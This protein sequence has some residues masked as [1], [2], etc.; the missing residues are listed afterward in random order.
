MN[1]YARFDFDLQN[2][3]NARWIWH[4]LSNKGTLFGSHCT[5]LTGLI[6]LKKKL[7]YPA[8]FKVDTDYRLLLYVLCKKGL[9]WMILEE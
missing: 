1:N 8:E 7:N 3:K 2:N 5:T 9:Q 4:A 6:V